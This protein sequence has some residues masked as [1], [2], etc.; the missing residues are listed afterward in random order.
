MSAP[1]RDHLT[2]REV[3]GRRHVPTFFS[4]LFLDEL[5]TALWVFT[6][7]WVASH[8]ASPLATGLVLLAAGVPYAVFLVVGGSWADRF[9]SAAVAKWTL[10]ARLI[11]LLSWWGLAMAGRGGQPELIVTAGLLGAIS[12]LHQPAMLAYPTRLVPANGQG[13]SMV[14]E[15][16]IARLAQ[17]A[18]GFVGGWATNHWGRGA[19][20]MIGA[21]GL[22]VALVAVLSVWRAGHRSLI[23]ESLETEPEEPLGTLALEG[24]RWIAQHSLLRR[25][26]AVQAAISALVASLLLVLLPLQARAEGWGAR[27]YGIAFGAFGTGMLVGSLSALVLAEGKTG[28]SPRVAICLAGAGSVSVAVLGVTSSAAAAA[29]CSFIAGLALGPVG[30][31]LSGVLRSSTASGNALATG[32]VMAVLLLVTDAAEPFVLLGSSVLVGLVSVRGSALIVGV[33]S[34]GVCLWALVGLRRVHPR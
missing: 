10:V 7:G 22:A 34:V 30:P 13:S 24:V 31:T 1:S 14:M 12:G 5:A 11:V 6:V 25:T 21:V 3:L 17:A 23:S 32:R 26:V 18:G 4:A 15:R 19:P 8:A 20:A 16:T 33:S 9:G 27:D 28:L 2:P 29:T